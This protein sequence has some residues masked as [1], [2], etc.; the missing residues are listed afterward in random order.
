MLLDAL[1]CHIGSPDGPGRPPVEG[2][3]SICFDPAASGFGADD[4]ALTRNGVPVSLTS[5]TVSPTQGPSTVFEVSGL[6]DATD[7]A[8]TYV[9]TVTTGSGITSDLGDLQSDVC[10]T[11]HVINGSDNP[12]DI[13]LSGS[14]AAVSVRVN[15]TTYTLD[16][17]AFSVLCVNGLD[18]DD[19]LK[20][21]FTDGSPLPAGG[22]VYD[23]GAGDDGLEIEAPNGMDPVHFVLGDLANTEE[24]S[25]TGGA[26]VVFDDNVA[27]DPDAP[28]LDL[29]L[30]DAAKALFRG[31]QT[32][33]AG[34]HVNDHS[35]A[36]LVR[37]RYRLLRTHLLSIGPTGKFDL[38]DGGLAIDY[39]AGASPIGDVMGWIRTGYDWGAWD[40]CGITST[41][42]WLDER[43]YSL[44][45]SPGFAN[46]GDLLE[47]FGYNYDE[48]MPFL[49]GYDVTPT[50]VLV[51]YTV[52]GDMNLD[53][54]VDDLDVAILGLC[55]DGGATGG[56]YW[57][58]GDIYLYDGLIDDLD[59][60]LIG[61]T[62]GITFLYYE[63]YNGDEVDYLA[64]TA[65]LW[66]VTPVRRGSPVDEVTIPF[67][68][69]VQGLD[70][71]DLSL[72]RDGTPVDWPESVSLTPVDDTTYVL[73][74][75]AD[76]TGQT[77]TY[78]LT[79]SVGDITD[80][81][82]PPAHP[83]AGTGE[84]VSWTMNAV[85]L[86]GDAA[87][88]EGA[89]YVLDLAIDG[90][91]ADD[92]MSLEI[93]W[94]DGTHSTGTRPQSSPYIDWGDDIT[95]EE[96]THTWTAT[97]IYHTPAEPYSI[98]VV[99][100]DGQGTYTANPLAVTVYG[101]PVA[102]DATVCVTDANDL[103]VEWSEDPYAEC[104]N[105]YKGTDPDNLA[106]CQTGLTGLSYTDPYDALDPLTT[107]YYKVEAV[108]PLGSSALSTVVHTRT[109][110]APKG[111]TATG[112]NRKITL[113]WNAVSGARAYN[114]YR[115]H[116]RD[117]GYWAW[118][119][120]DTEVPFP[121]S[122]APFEDTNLDEGAWY[123]YR[124]TAMIGDQESRLSAVEQATTL[125]SVPQRPVAV[126]EPLAQGPHSEWDGDHWFGDHWFGTQLILQWPACPGASSYKVYVDDNPVGTAADK[127][128][129]VVYLYETDTGVHEYLMIALNG[130]N[131]TLI[132]T[133]TGVHEYRVTALNSAGETAKSESVVAPTGSVPQPP[134]NVWVRQYHDD[135][136]D[137]WGTP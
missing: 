101:I 6:D 50:S 2:S 86:G 54:V 135:D 114:V 118:E 134:G 127:N 117:D 52:A 62:Y 137:R 11:W 31:Q 33:L 78:T 82:G 1:T 7:E 89:E 45:M 14:S 124:V 115:E 116:L 97:H 49:M 75:L 128:F 68:K 94:G 47:L 105:L 96:A 111:L 81:A 84:V 35:V 104:Y 91:N 18:G 80:L 56:H 121:T 3:I 5:V 20:L 39:G 72:S 44:Q 16:V 67:S 10:F 77:G 37:G 119:L 59:V 42:G 88:D 13:A 79:L 73:G 60:A 63:S 129:L 125:P 43:Y 27:A 25:L 71:D 99:A 98:S 15:T 92:I 51:R 53:G 103:L 123:S 30:N 23:G 8:G 132:G 133:Y 130:T 83:L 17:S 32:D 113:T 112:G 106:S 36:E 70:L 100:T 87:V 107:Y 131:G 120:L 41:R 48:N 65:A 64:P 93:T 38:N 108:N 57:N 21:D 55:Y 102:P 24:L 126:E 46:N 66:G 76:V 40:G 122:V 61:L 109:P 4:L 85:E 69:I 29:T 28:I 22:L 136:N 12:D 9:L 26:V 110:L 34:L 90:P 19:T 95:W 58:E 74:G